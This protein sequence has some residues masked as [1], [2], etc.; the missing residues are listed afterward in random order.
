MKYLFASLLIPFSI[1]AAANSPR[2]AHACP[3]QAF[4]SVDAS[5]GIRFLSLADGDS[6]VPASAKIL[7][8]TNQER[9]ETENNPPV[10]SLV[11]QAGLVVPLR[12]EILAT[13]G[14]S[15]PR[16]VTVYVLTPET[17]LGEGVRYTMSASIRTPQ[18]VQFTVR[19][20]S[21]REPVKVELKSMQVSLA[22]HILGGGS[23][24]CL[25]SP[26]HYADYTWNASASAVLAYRS[27]EAGEASEILG[28][29]HGPGSDK[30]LIGSGKPD[31]SSSHC[32]VLKAYDF[33]LGAVASNTLCSA[34]PK[35]PDPDLLPVDAGSITG[36]IPDAGAGAVADAA[37]SPPPTASGGCSFGAR[38]SSG[39]TGG[40]FMF[41]G[42]WW[43]SRHARRKRA[44]RPNC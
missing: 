31:A 8:A 37:I 4:V 36:G 29:W 19:S 14:L 1:A 38:S 22:S 35:Q 43:L 16:K 18:R 44:P 30:I 40:L 6:D 12:K 41:L 5:S 9:Y 20:S 32:I 13:T 17:P 11:D 3:G 2:P 24:T 23:S 42:A 25:P 10:F 15:S 39:P 28:A 33:E 27:N 26:Y 21:I 34:P 7:V